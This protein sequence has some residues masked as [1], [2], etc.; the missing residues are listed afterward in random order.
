ML[1]FI[2]YSFKKQFQWWNFCTWAK[3]YLQLVKSE[4][5]ELFVFQFSH[6]IQPS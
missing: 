6:I 3:F 5:F 2:V 1:I 4:K